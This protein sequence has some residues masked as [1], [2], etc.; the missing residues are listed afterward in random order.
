MK[1][2]GESP[3]HSRYGDVMTEGK[4]P[5]VWGTNAVVLKSPWSGSPSLEDLLSDHEHTIVLDRF[6][7]VGGFNRPATPTECRVAHNS[8]ALY[9][10]FRCGEPDM[11]FPY[12][13]LDKSLWPVADWHSLHG[14]PSAA[15]NWPPNPD[16]VDFLIQ[17][18]A[19]VPSYYQFAATP[20]GLS[21]GCERQLSF[22]TDV[23][24][25]A[26]AAARDSS[27]IVSNVEGFEATVTRGTDEWLVFFEIPWQTLGGK[28]KSYFGFL[29]M[30]TRWRD[31][32]FCSPVAFDINE[33]MPVDLLIETYF[34]GAAQVRDSQSSLCQLPSGILRWQRPAVLTYPNV[35]TCQQIWQMESSLS[36]P[37]DKNNLAQR[38]YLTERWMG[39][40]MLEGFTPLPGAWDSLLKNNLTLALFRQ[41]VN[42]AL[43]KNDPEQAYRLLDTYLGQLDKMSRW[44]YA[45]GSPGD[46]LKD[47]WTPVT[48]AESLEVQGGTLLMRCKAG[49]HQVDLRLALPKTGGIR[50][51]GS[52][53]GY[54]RPDS[55][56]PLKATQTPGSCS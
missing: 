15:N 34:S 40:M 9:V 36:T 11:S 46:I 8:D 29:P 50:I 41:K 32:E 6:Y 28:P 10:V 56:L 5:L 44:W 20:Q 7:R 35:D 48:S 47:A 39:L 16:E 2:G 55:L 27:V 49:G 43:Q 52:E 33:A 25:D 37:T 26:A 18:D 54:W 17:S 45:D 19:G 1:A 22:S 23:A 51:Y 42:A 38:L 53:E 14:L 24:A 12:A 30:R 31:G 13:N 4:E 21:F 3:S